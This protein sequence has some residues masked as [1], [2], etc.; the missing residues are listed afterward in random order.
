[1]KIM[2]ILCALTLVMSACGN[3]RELNDAMSPAP[4]VDAPSVD[5]PQ[6]P[7]FL[8]C[9]GL[10]M[11]CGL[12]GSGSCCDSL[13][14]PGGAFDRSYDAAG[15]TSSGNTSF[16][17]T[18]SSFRL[19]KYKVTVGRFRR[20]VNAG[21]GTQSSPPVPGAGAHTTLS[22]SGW[23]VGWN[24]S[25]EANT[26]A[27]IAR[28]KC[29]SIFQTWTDTPAANEHRPIN[30]ITWYEAMAFC[31]WDGGYLPTEAEWNYAAAGGDQQRAYPWSSPPGSLT[32]DAFH[33]SY[34]DGTNCVGDGAAG[35]ALT[36]LVAVGTTPAGDGR[37]GQSDLAGNVYEWTLD[38]NVPEYSNPC[39]DCA[40]T[41]AGVVMERRVRGGYFGDLAK[42]LRRAFATSATTRSDTTTSVFVAQGH[43]E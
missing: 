38:W 14:V 22:G 1:M 39:V 41:T 2:M 10:P 9:V 4:S 6:P 37:W 30:C 35:C 36:D 34:S 33:A 11:T 15:D 42:F 13:D 32:I 43:R 24:A 31:I 25:L 20:F 12:S 16:P 27:L 17:A 5:A 28:L 18:I 40:A 23:D 26:A 29:D 8:S 19:D 7:Q 3:V 21:V